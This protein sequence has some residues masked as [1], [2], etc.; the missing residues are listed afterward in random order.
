M[1]EVI[2]AFGSNVG[3]K[4]DQIQTAIDRLVDSGLRCDAISSCYKS[5]PVGMKDQPDFVN[6]VGRFFC[7]KCSPFDVLRLILRIETEMGRV[8]TVE[9]GPRSIDIDLIF[10]GR[11]Q[12]A[13]NS[14]TVPHGEYGSRRFVL[15]PMCELIP[16]FQPPGR[17]GSSVSELLEI[18]PDITS[19]PVKISEFCKI[20]D[21]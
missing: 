16:S 7:S 1:T 9:N 2:L 13:T 21:E 10:F 19:N 20:S 8:R 5:K 18:C 15:E 3:D 12:I 14:L 17:G 4:V 11:Q 6:A